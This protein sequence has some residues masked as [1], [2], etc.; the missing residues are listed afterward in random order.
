MSNKEKEGKYSEDEVIDIEPD[1]LLS[2]TEE[3]IK[4]SMDR[5]SVFNEL[6]ITDKTASLWQYKPVSEDEPEIFEEYMSSEQDIEGGRI[7]AARVRGK[8]H[9]HDGTNC[10]DWFEYDVNGD[11]KILI[12]SDGAGSRKF[13]RIGAKAACT[14]AAAYLRENL[15]NASEE[16]KA[17]LS[18]P[19][20]DSGFMEGCSVFA[21]ILQ[22]S[23]LKAKEAVEAA[24]DERK[25]QFRYLDLVER[26]LELKDLACTFLVCI[27]LP[28]MV[29][30]SKEYFAAAI[31]IGDGI[32]CSVDRNSSFEKALRLLSVPDSGEYSGETDFITSENQTKKESLMGKT[33]I[34]RGKS[35][36]FMVMT[37]GVADDY[38]PNSP[39]LLR[40]YIDL[41][42]NG[43]SE[44]DDSTSEGEMPEIIP[45]PLTHPWVNDNDRKVMCQYAKRIEERTGCD[46][47]TLWKNTAL[48]KKASL[49][50]SDPDLPAERKERLLRWLDN[51]TERGSFDDRT[52]V[53]LEFDQE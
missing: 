47:E 30:E 50:N 36:A 48:I 52:L 16:D 1:E 32:I 4:E 24:F 41:C 25:T 22:D 37:D 6:N 3:D 10:D 43:I 49:V 26:D 19:L 42:L 39:E 34:M 44:A 40:L 8:K 7:T 21:N 46:L 23:V 11:W 15:D 5:L 14:A 20:D 31:Q 27:V 33:K 9:K 35:S 17:K 18:L 29:G 45:D 13:S 2:A 51:Y 28:V 53:L 12:A 38:F